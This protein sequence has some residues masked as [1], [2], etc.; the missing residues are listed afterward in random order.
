MT[1]A[2]KV[3]RKEDIASLSPEDVRKGVA[4]RGERL[5]K[6]FE[7]AGEH[8]DPKLV[9]TI[10]APDG[11]ALAKQIAAMND[12]LGWF[13]ERTAELDA[14]DAIKANAER[15]RKAGQR[16]AGADPTKFAPGS[17]P[18]PDKDAPKRMSLGQA[19]VKSGAYA[20]A[21]KRER[22]NFL[23]EELDAQAVIEAKSP[24]E[25]KAVFETTAGWA[26]ETTRT[27]RVVLDAQREIEVTDAIPT[28]PTTQ[29]AIV[30]MEETTFTNSA[31]ERSEGG[32]YAESTLALTEQSVTVRSIGT[33][34]PMT[35]EQ[36]ADEAGAAAYVDQR[37][38]FMVR[39]R[40]DGQILAGNGTPPNLTGTYNVGSINTQ[41]KGADPVPDAVYKGM[42]LC[43][44]TGRALPN[45]V[46]SH[47][48]DWQAVRLLR[49]ADGIYIWGSPS[50]AG[51][52]QIWGLPVV[53]TTAATEGSMLVGDYARFSSLHV[54]QGLE[55]AVGFVNDDFT[56]GRVT[57]RA[58]LRVAMVHYRPAAFCEVTGV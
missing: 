23:V 14:M 6:V 17:D 49:T 28:L 45:V 26:P 5:H 20:A 37:L 46:F 58:G 15:A 3:E 24:F 53:L 12:E 47:P 19:F 38:G 25:M 18:D 2:V 51:P 16:P 11:Q 8:L 39:Q 31:A 54:R 1:F 10:E 33:S 41:A 50:E 42:D 35:D 21:T 43:R 40:L 29:S 34:L 9:K 55:L 4:E 52:T 7:E 44:V 32:A 48:T 36:L 13:Q 30:Y 22:G 27:G 57:V 56:D